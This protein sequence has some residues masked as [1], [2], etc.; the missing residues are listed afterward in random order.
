MPPRATTVV[1]I[2]QRLAALGIEYEELFENTDAGRRCARVERHLLSAFGLL[3]S[4]HPERLSS[5][6]IYLMSRI[7]RIQGMVKMQMGAVSSSELRG[8]RLQQRVLD[9]ALREQ[10]EPGHARR[11]RK[12]KR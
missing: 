6:A 12:A 7:L 5:V 4:P 2:K 3:V 1:K 9:R 11:A 8:Q 10:G